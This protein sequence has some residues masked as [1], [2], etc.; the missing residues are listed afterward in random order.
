M[1]FLAFTH[2]SPFSSTISHSPEAVQA[3]TNLLVAP[4][5]PDSSFVPTSCVNSSP[6]ALRVVPKRKVKYQKYTKVGGEECERKNILY[7]LPGT[8]K[9]GSKKSMVGVCPDAA[10]KKYMLNTVNKNIILILLFLEQALPVKASTCIS[11][12]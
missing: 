9:L 6:C 3:R 5:G 10:Y 8:A 11:R 7:L 1:A 4:F 12:A 2:G